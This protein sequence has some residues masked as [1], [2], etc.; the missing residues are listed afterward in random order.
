MGKIAVTMS[1][2]KASWQV[3]KKDKELLF[4]PVISGVC[5]LS[6]MT[7]F[8]VLGL[9]HGWLK[10]FAK[11]ASVQQKNLAYWYLFLFFIT[12]AT[13]SLFFSIQR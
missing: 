13:W 6:V 8:I 9:E 1:L 11:D 10:S 5:C 4:L 12:V 3:L 7:I 2:M